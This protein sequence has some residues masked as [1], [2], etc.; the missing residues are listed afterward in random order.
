[1][2]LTYNMINSNLEGETG[3]KECKMQSTLIIF[4]TK[5]LLKL[6]ENNPDK[7]RG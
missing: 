7:H 6:V 3:S 2:K 5:L 1:M 4:L